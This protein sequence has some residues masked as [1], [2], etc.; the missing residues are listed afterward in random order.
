LYIHSPFIE[1]FETLHSSKVAHDNVENL[2]L[3][4]ASSVFLQDSDAHDRNVGIIKVGEKAYATRI[5]FDYAFD[6]GNNAYIGYTKYAGAA[7]FLNRVNFRRF[8][9]PSTFLSEKFASSCSAIANISAQHLNYAINGAVN[10]ISDAVDASSKTWLEQRTLYIEFIRQLNPECQKETLESYTKEKILYTLKEELS[11]KLVKQQQEMKDLATTIRL[12]L[13]IRDGN[14][15][16]FSKLLAENPKFAKEEIC[17]VNNE[18]INKYDQQYTDADPNY[19]HIS[20]LILSSA[21]TE[22]REELLNIV[23]AIPDNLKEASKDSSKLH[24]VID[25]PVKKASD[26]ELIKLE[27][28]IDQVLTKHLTDTIKADTASKLAQ[29]ALDILSSSQLVSQTTLEQYKGNVETLCVKACQNSQAEESSTVIEALKS[30]L[31]GTLILMLEADKSKTAENPL[32]NHQKPWVIE[33]SNAK[34]AFDSKPPF[35]KA[36]H[37]VTGIEQ[38]Y[39]AQYGRHAK[40]FLINQIVASG[41]FSEKPIYEIRKDEALSQSFI[42]VQLI[43]MA[44]GEMSNKKIGP[45]AQEYILEKVA[46]HV[47]N[48]DLFWNSL[49]SLINSI[50]NGSD[51]GLQDAMKKDAEA[52]AK[53]AAT[54]AAKTSTTPQQQDLPTQLLDQAKQAGKAMLSQG[55][56]AGGTQHNSTPSIQQ[57]GRNTPSK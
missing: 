21:P 10:D 14:T 55:V 7:D 6:R 15:A 12:Q 18:K 13:A 49:E 35:E 47:D 44:E 42:A 24:Q 32:G 17:W 50:K 38:E 57:P 37:I 54:S 5:D 16:S 22:K 46:K 53:Q 23:K 51:T 25:T 40:Q 33:Q 41:E 19:S 31:V 29:Q 26:A 45:N 27:E 4:L 43:D 9:D 11:N 48:Q 28:G 1:N 2:D 52:Q 36:A 56:T 20:E 8:Y 30:E 39:G 34:K 3:A